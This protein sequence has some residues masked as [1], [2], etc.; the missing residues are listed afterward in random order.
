MERYL[1]GFEPS[2]VPEQDSD[3]PGE[4][5]GQNPAPAPFGRPLVAAWGM[6]VNST[7]M[8]IGLHKCGLV[9][10]LTLAADTGGERPETYKYLFLFDQWMADAGFPRHP[11]EWLRPDGYDDPAF[12]LPERHVLN[13]VVAVKNDG[14]HGT[15]ERN[16]LTNKTLPSIA[17]GFKSCSDKY[18]IR[19]QNKFLRSWPVAI[20]AWEAGA[21]VW[22]AIGYDAGEAH[23]A[24][25][26]EDKEFS[27]YYPLLHWGWG[28]D[29]CVKEIQ[30]AGLPIPR[31]SACFFC[32]SST[33]R[34]VVELHE[35][36]PG[37]YQRA[38]AMER[39]AADSN[40][41]IKGLGRRYSWEKLMSLPLFDQAQFCDP[42]PDNVPCGCFDGTE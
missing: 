30:C 28:R 36:L 42:N 13:C 39:N 31:K 29:E 18:K 11:N 4:A 38:I 8:L 34:E 19:P 32:P 1:P 35:K 22:R 9:P 10:E 7:A 17:Y 37:L 14:M 2:V 33:K 3:H 20:A 21:K 16:C 40:T 26:A 25:I 5:G 41:D 24:G 12:G 15:L 27:Y 23:R 6:G